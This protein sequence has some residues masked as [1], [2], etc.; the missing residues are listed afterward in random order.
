MEGIFP[1]LTLGAGFLGGI[2]FPLANT[3]YMGKRKEIGRIG[4]LING[5]DLLGSAAGALVISVILVPIVGIVQG[6]SIVFALN[7]SAI[8]CL[9]MGALRK[10]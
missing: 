6:V 3:V 1:F 4:G 9:V 2:H 7:V 5:I 8:L 10:D